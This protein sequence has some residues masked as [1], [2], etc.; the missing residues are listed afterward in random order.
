MLSAADGGVLRELLSAELNR[1]ADIYGGSI[2]GRLRLPMEIIDGVR[3]WMGSRFLI[4]FR[5]IAEEFVPGGMS[6]Q[7]ARVIAKRVV[8]A[9]VSLLDVTVD[10]HTESPVARF[11]GWCIPLA[12]SIKRVIPDVPVIG[13]GLLSDPYLADSVVQDGSVDLVMLGRTLR[14]HPDWPLRAR[15]LLSEAGPRRTLVGL[16]DE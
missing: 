7:D 8:A 2:A 4:G 12:N 13:S 16:E 1:R 6:L 3:A 5:L 9:G 11:P 14:R 15:D 10:S